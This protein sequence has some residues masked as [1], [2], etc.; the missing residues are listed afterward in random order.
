MQSA[1]GTEAG[2]LKVIDL[3][4]AAADDCTMM[5]D[6]F[7]ALRGLVPFSSGVFMPVDAATMEL[8]SGVCFD[9]SM[10]QMALY[11]AHYAAV[12]P[13][14]LRQSGP[15]PLNRSLLLSDV[16][17]AG[18]LARSEFSD[19]QVQVPY[20]Y[21]IG[22]LAGVAQ[23]AIAAI[24]VH[25]QAHDRDFTRADQEVFDCI[26]P[27]L[28]RAVVL[29]RLASDSRQRTETGIAVFAR[30][31]KSLFLN[32]VAHR[33]LR[34]TSP[35]AV[36]DAL[37][38]YGSGVIRLGSRTL[39][40]SRLPWS[41]ASLLRPFAVDETVISPARERQSATDVAETLDDWLEKKQRPP[42]AIIV[43]LRPFDARTDLIRRLAHYS[44]SPR[45]SEIAMWAMR[46]LTNSEIAGQVNIGAQTVRDHFQEIYYRVGVRSRSELLAKV[47][48]TNGGMPPVRQVK[49][50]QLL[51]QKSKA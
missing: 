39:G 32:G 35:A 45:Q 22:M 30:D 21:A 36:L 13:F 27:H 28:A 3:A 11:L 6:V 50:G 33:F 43:A 25:R 24:S 7:T 29:R 2:L 34:K 15:P 4:Y 10:E 12:D 47:L 5:G 38:T 46:G 31:G 20:C 9:C 49:T 17:T 44:L 19:F 23:Q 40:L 26:G 51:D 41:A 16:L 18:E 14:V 37:P 48:G 8:Q 42:S 1:F